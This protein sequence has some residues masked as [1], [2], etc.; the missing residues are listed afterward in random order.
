MTI[1]TVE[2]DFHDAPRPVRVRFA[3]TVPD[4]GGAFL[5]CGHLAMLI[6]AAQVA[7]ENNCPLDFRFDGEPDIIGALDCM[8]AVAWLQIPVRRFYVLPV[9]NNRHVEIIAKGDKSLA[10]GL[11][12]WHLS[13]SF[14]DLYVEN[15]TIIVRGIEFKYKP[16][17]NE[18]TDAERVWGTKPHNELL[19]PLLMRDGQKMSKS[20]DN[21]IRWSALKDYP[22]D[23]VKSTFIDAMASGE[24]YEWKQI[25]KQLAARIKL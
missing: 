16:I 24:N 1:K 8:N 19:Y 5:H 15:N 11:T 18:I 22:V 10:A 20:L 25:L 13:S 2:K 23:A 7:T 14:D 4:G 17:R 12:N 3:P 6:M 21:G 9:I